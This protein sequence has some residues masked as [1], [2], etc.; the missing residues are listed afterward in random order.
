MYL[1]LLSFVLG[2]VHG[3]TPDEHTWP[4]TLSYA[5]GTFT[6]SGGA[7]AGLLF[8]LGFTLQRAFISELSYLALAPFLQNPEVNA[9]V[10]VVVGIVM[11]ASGFY[12][13]R[14]G[15]YLHYHRLA[16]AI[17]RFYHV[18]VLRKTG[19]EREHL[20]EHG[21]LAPHPVL[22][23]R[24]V[25]LMLTPVHGAIAGFGFG[26]FALVLYTVIAPQMGSAALAW[27][28]GALFGIGTMVMQML[29]GAAIGYWLRHRRYTKEQISFIGRLTSGRVL[30]YGGIAFVAVGMLLYFLPAV[31]DYGV[32]TGISFTGLGTLDLGF[33]MVVA[34]I[35]VIAIPSY[36]L[37][38]REAGRRFRS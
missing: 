14:K 32:S 34:V 15:I 12:I 7:A 5:L 10:Y 23:P 20:L 6:A 36:W 9:F 11:S 28:P 35:A 30:A 4:I 31:G 29:F 2:L 37:A 22:E 26:A 38:V 19:F 18:S 3:A 24:K 8:S 13:L 21:A 1:L 33:F 27:L 25:P 16:N 17:E